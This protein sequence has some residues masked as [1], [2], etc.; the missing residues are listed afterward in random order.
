MQYRLRQAA[1]PSAGRELGVPERERKCRTRRGRDGRSQPRA[2]GRRRTG[3]GWLD[4]RVRCRK[5]EPDG[6]AAPKQPDGVIR[7]VRLT[8]EP[9]RARR[10][11]ECA[12][13]ETHVD[14]KHRPVLESWRSGDVL[15]HG[16]GVRALNCYCKLARDSAAAA[17][18]VGSINAPTIQSTG[19]MIPNEK[20]ALWPLRRVNMPSVTQAAM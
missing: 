18:G 12:R 13:P 17:A 16:S 15:G 8:H 20:S 9:Q 10:C 4:K 14:G 11:R 2:A 19:K 1:A 3:P 7:G 5:C 6:S